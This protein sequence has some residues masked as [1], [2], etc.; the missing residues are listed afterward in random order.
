MESDKKY[1]SYLIVGVVLLLGGYIGFKWWQSEERK[2]REELSY[3]VFLVAKNL[4][5][6][7]YEEGLKLIEEIEKEYGNRKMALFGKSYSLLID[8]I[9]GKDKIAE[10]I[11][12][13]FED[14][15]IKNLFAERLAYERKDINGIKT[16]KEDAF[17]K[18]SARFLEGLLLK[19][20]GDKEKAYII[21][22]DIANKD[23][24][25]FSY[26]A[27]YLIIRE[28]IE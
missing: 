7:K 19:Q 9:K 11:Y 28:G 12:K 22:K 13:N 25:Y 5:E 17:N 10:I 26:V 2:K 14:E 6:G 21:F 16:I 18:I 24:P 23:V 4:K 20:K 1:I 8:N 3:K 15:D 27:E